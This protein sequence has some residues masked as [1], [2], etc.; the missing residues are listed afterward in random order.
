VLR[1]TGQRI[2]RSGLI[3][4]NDRKTIN[5]TLR[6]NGLSSPGAGSSLTIPGYVS[7]PL[8]GGQVERGLAFNSDVLNTLITYWNAYKSG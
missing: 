1:A 3:K 4:E 8:T 6:A 5:K 7:S 2:N